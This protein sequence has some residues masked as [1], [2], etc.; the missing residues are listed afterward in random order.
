[1]SDTATRELMR[2]SLQ[3]AIPLWQHRLRAMDWADVQRRAHEAAQVVAEKGD[4][5]QF[6]SKKRGETAAA[7]NALAEGVAALSFCPGGVT[8]LGDHWEADHTASDQPT[9]NRSARA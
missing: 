9:D 1:M 3:A 6:K 4:I 7:F 2:I 5:L 8:F